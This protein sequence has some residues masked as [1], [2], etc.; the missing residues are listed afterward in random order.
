MV[1][2]LG[3]L[4]KFKIKFDDGNKKGIFYAG[5]TIKGNLKVKL[6]DDMKMRG[7]Y[8][9]FLGKAYVHWSEQH[10][11]GSGKNRR[12]YTKHYRAREQYFHHRHLVY[13]SWD[14]ETDSTIELKKGKHKYPFEFTLPEGLPSSFEGGTGH[15]R[16]QVSATIDKPWK[17]DHNTRRPFTVISILD[18]NRQPDA[19]KA[20]GG[21]GQKHLCCLCCK[22]GPI[23]ANFHIERTGFV[24][25]E[26]IKLYSEISN[27]ASRKMA[28]SYV[29]LRMH[30][31]FRAGGKSRYR[32]T[33]VA[34]I[35]KGEIE[36]HGEES[37]TGEELVIPPIPPSF[38]AGC[39]IIDISYVL[40]MNV[41]PAGP[42][43][44]LEV[45]LKVI[46]GTIPLRSVVEAS[47]PKP[48]PPELAQPKAPGEDALYS[49]LDFE[50]PPPVYADT[51]TGQ[52]DMHEDGDNEHLRGET[53]WA[54]AYPSY[55]FGYTAAALPEQKTK[56]AE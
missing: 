13:G 26:A 47:K 27:G 53:S 29:D 50:L 38:L 10:S 3:K 51:V 36:G 55:N 49:S 48:P 34:R 18:L 6:D 54:P 11:R 46:I 8:L 24:P 44:D 45:P 33:E 19:M 16:Y 17:F 23:E 20:P 2:G 56:E 25:G 41:D 39:N 12:T 43:F 40:Q 30:Q 1:F 21:Q 52:V 28:S 9:V 7:I 15:V 4:D 22:S 14:H 31:V 42:A 35:T 37:W 32:T 5:T